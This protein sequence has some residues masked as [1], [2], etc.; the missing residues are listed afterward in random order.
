MGLRVKE[1][2]RKLT[3]VTSVRNYIHPTL[4]VASF[5]HVLNGFVSSLL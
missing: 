5:A 2:E 1:T 4:A 3:M